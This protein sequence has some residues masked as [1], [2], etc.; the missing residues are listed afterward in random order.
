MRVIYFST[1]HLLIVDIGY[2][3]IKIRAIEVNFMSPK[4]A[5][6]PIRLLNIRKYQDVF[7][8]V[9][10]NAQVIAQDLKE[11]YLIET[12]NLASSIKAV[13]E[14]GTAGKQTVLDGKGPAPR[15]EEILKSLRDT[16]VGTIDG[17]LGRGLIGTVTPFL[18][19]AV[20][21]S[22]IIGDTSENRERFNRSDFMVN[23]LRAGG[24]G[25][26]HDYIGALLLLY[27]LN[28]ALNSLRSDD[29]DIF[30]IHGPLV[31]SLGQY[32]DYHFDEQDLRQVMGDDNFEDFVN[33]CWEHEKI[34]N[35][36]AYKRRPAPRRTTKPY[37]TENNFLVATAF[38]INRIY[39]AARD[40][41][42]LIAG[43]VER[44]RSTELSQRMIFDRFDELY[45]KNLKWFK[46]VVGKPLTGK[47]HTAKAKYIKEF[48]DNL[49]YTDTL[50]FGSI[51][52]QGNY[53][54]FQESR[55]NRKQTE[56][57]EMGLD[58]GLIKP[59]EHLSELIPHSRFT[60]MRT[61]IFN[62]PFKV[63]VP[64]WF[65]SAD[66][67]ILIESVFAFSQFLPK[68]AFPVNLDVVDKVAKVSNWITNALMMVIRQEIF[69]SL[70]EER[71]PLTMDELLLLG[72]KARDWNI[73]PK[74]G[75][76]QYRR[77]F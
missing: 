3:G 64:D 37:L 33:Y 15:T 44:S 14:S 57:R 7:Q 39:A 13:I 29:Y 20:T 68:Y 65:T 59:L 19:R 8:A 36:P 34:I 75:G 32:S 74:A 60:Y 67:K 63:E 53:S 40:K 6:A 41:G 49:G 25:T 2:K 11:H 56:N 55:T 52:D 26:D 42:T 10:V 61:S 31:R 73:R 28:G 4:S 21:Y 76:M 46:S 50:L 23:R 38:T 70:L 1:Y 35:A 22:V 27:E 43:V 30:I 48:L 18:M 12:D 51:L 62:A 71:R 45:K 69:A 58:I 24:F 16:K 47:T 54:G 17:G 66:E 5:K 72:G 77:G 9:V